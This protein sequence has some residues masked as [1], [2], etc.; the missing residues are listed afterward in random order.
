M[1]DLEKQWRD[2]QAQDGDGTVWCIAL[3]CIILGLLSALSGDIADI[4]A[5][6]AAG[7]VD[8]AITELPVPVVA[9]AIA[10]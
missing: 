5:G 4:A 3:C 9:W 2:P 6:S 8:L 1:V 7:K 10:V